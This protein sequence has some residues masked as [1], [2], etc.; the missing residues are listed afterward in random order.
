MASS[1]DP[2]E[3]S[4]LLRAYDETTEDDG[5]DLRVGG[6]ARASRPL[7]RYG[8]SNSLSRGLRQRMAPITQVGQFS[9]FSNKDEF[10]L[11]LGSRIRKFSNCS[12]SPQ[13]C[14]QSAVFSH[15]ILQVLSFA[16]VQQ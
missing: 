4:P 11:W 13:P 1:A 6:G 7:N 9:L 15:G 2:T 3:R 16:T 8:S 12:F 10:Y 5:A 14:L